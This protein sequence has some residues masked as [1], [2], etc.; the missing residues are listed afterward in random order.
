MEKDSSLKI[1][2]QCFNKIIPVSDARAKICPH[3]FIVALVFCFLGDAKTHSIEAMRRFMMA[4]L[5]TEIKRHSFW[6][7]LSRNRLKKLLRSLIC[8]LIKWLSQVVFRGGKILL[9]LN[10]SGVLL[11]DSSSI[12]LWDGAKV[13]HPGTRTTAGIKWHA[14]FDLFSGVMTWF[15]L[16]PTSTS[17]R[18]CFPDLKSLMGK[19]IIFDLG[20]WDYGLLSSIDKIGGFFLSRIKSNSAIFIDG[21]VEG[22]AS[23]HVGKKLTDI[24]LKRK[25]GHIIEIVGSV[26]YKK[27]WMNLRV[28]GFWNPS[29]KCYHWYCTNLKVAACLIYPL[30]RL[31][32]QIELIFKGC[33]NSLNANQITSS[34]E[35][36]IESLLLASIAAHLATSSI[37]EVGKDSL[38]DDQV[39]SLSFQRASKVSVVLAVHFINYLIKSSKKYFVELKSKIELFSNE[40]Y[41]PNYR[42]RNTSLNIFNDILEKS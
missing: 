16:T 34:D 6:E 15:K 21:I 10:V 41:D 3:N 7:R 24:K 38:S 13:S 40:L 14:C 12:S 23:C 33:K 26:L 28:V 27:K 11:I 5:G 2:K 22:L 9:Q 35:N 31:R 8:L 19:L 17:D 4:Q 37:L 29:G 42:K 30:Y 25:K 18:K 36:I 20:Y 39:L 1:I 32:W